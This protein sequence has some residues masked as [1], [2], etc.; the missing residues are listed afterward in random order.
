MTDDIDAYV[1]ERDEALTKLDTVWLR[2]RLPKSMSLHQ[3]LII[4]HKARYECVRIDPKIREESRTWL[5]ARGHS[6]LNNFPW[7]P[8]GELPA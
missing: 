8:E 2:Q 7:P 1:K 6:R 5:E 4:A 3:L